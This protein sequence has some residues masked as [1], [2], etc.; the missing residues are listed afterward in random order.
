MNVTWP[1]SQRQMATGGAVEA[2]ALEDL[3]P[4]TPADQTVNDDRGPT[5]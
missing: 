2:S 5:D 3:H 1:R 4:T